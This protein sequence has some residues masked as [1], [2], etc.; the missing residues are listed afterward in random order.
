MDVRELQLR[1]QQSPKLVTEEGIMM[2]VKEEH[3]K[4][5]LLPKLVTEEK[6]IVFIH[7]KSIA[8]V[9]VSIIAVQFFRESYTGLLASTTI[10][11]R[12]EQYAYLQPVI[13]Q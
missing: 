11:M 6:I 4:K 5:Q 1:K 7:P 8:L 10:D 2:D 3:P 12:E 9:S 13:S